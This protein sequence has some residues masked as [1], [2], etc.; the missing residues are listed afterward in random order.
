[1]WNEI[2]FRLKAAALAA[3]LALAAPGAMADEVDI[4]MFCNPE[5]DSR[6]D[7]AIPLPGGGTLVFRKVVTPGKNAWGGTE[8]MIRM[9]ASGFGMFETPIK[10]MH[11]DGSFYDSRAGG[12]SYYI[13]KYEVSRGQV[14]LIL[15]NGDLDAGVAAL[16][17]MTGLSDDRKLASL[18]GSRLE[19]ALS[20]PAAGL[21]VDQIEEVIRTYNR[22]LIAERARWSKL[23][24]QDGE[25]G[26]IRLPTELEWEYAAVGG[27][28][29][30]EANLDTERFPFPEA[31][32]KDH[33]IS[34][35]NNRGGAAA[36]GVTKPVFGLYDMIGNVAEI[37]DGRFH[38]ELWQGRP[39]ASIARGGSYATAFRGA[40]DG[41]VRMSLREEFS[42]YKLVGSK[43]EETRSPFYGFRLAIGSNAATSDNAR[44]RLEQD[45]D[46]YLADIRSASAIG[47]EGNAVVGSTQEIDA[48]QADLARALERGEL[49][50]AE[51]R[52]AQA[53]LQRTQDQ[54]GLYAV[55]AA[56]AEAKSA[57]INLSLFRQTLGVVDGLSAAAE[58][59]KGLIAT[60][61]VIRDQ[62]DQYLAD[63]ETERAQLDRLARA[64]HADLTD[65]A[66]FDVFTAP[67]LRRLE[68]D[69]PDYDEVAWAVPLF[70]AHYVKAGSLTPAQIRNELIAAIR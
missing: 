32:W 11:V 70:R 24:S 63:I 10:P 15:G 68:T 41:G 38:T 48:L 1:M 57:I 59:L 13:G 67:A 34:S 40:A 5:P 58:E 69:W 16:A 2:L 28:K 29:G 52:S 9:G 36:I 42:R 37:V 30:V 66:S 54:L 62:Y 49:K 3:A 18:T 47:R 45:R 22:W 35:D 14:A 65:F 33:V 21:S 61:P 19:I 53:Q 17:D 23:P 44:K 60:S 27:R 4:A 55:Q 20:R 56:M 64:Y 50:E 43:I 6:A 51:I 46:I 12:W 31:D 26:F 25:P 39:G 8:R 7:M